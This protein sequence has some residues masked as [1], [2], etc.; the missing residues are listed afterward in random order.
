MAQS[1]AKSA[2]AN[3]Q[4]K[5]ES[6]IVRTK[7]KYVKKYPTAGKPAKYTSVEALQ[8]GIDKYFAECEIKEKPATMSGLAIN[9]GF[10]NRQSLLD[11]EGKDKYSGTI[12]AARARVEASVEERLLTQG[13]SAAGCIFNLKNNFGW[14]DKSE[15]EINFNGK[16]EAG[17]LDDQELEDRIKRIHMQ[18][19]SL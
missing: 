15:Q 10:I 3:I 11:Y 19:T 5:P 7:R 13:Q 9:L 18:L 6:Q 2:K 1:K 12:K 16:I 14:K 17:R 4:D 8:T